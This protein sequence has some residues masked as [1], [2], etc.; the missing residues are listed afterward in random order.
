MLRRTADDTDPVERIIV[1]NADQ[2]V[3]V[4]AL[5]DPEPRTRMIDRCVAAAYDA[6]MDALLALTKADLADPATL[7]DMYAPIGVQVVVSSRGDGQRHRRAGRRSG[8]RWTGGRRCS[9][10]TRAWASRRS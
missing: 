9:S 1:A 4:T 6:R 5:A 7:V 8:T 2:L 3:I 10:A